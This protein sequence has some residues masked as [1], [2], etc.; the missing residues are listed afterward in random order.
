MERIERREPTAVVHL[1]VWAGLLALTVLTVSLAGVGLGRLG[2]VLV[3]G[4]A[5]TK[6]A[7]IAAYFMHLRY[8]KIRLYV[9]LILIAL[10]T[11]A[12]FAGLT[13]LEVATR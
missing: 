11:L 7:L 2:I 4:I 1:A 3:L 13:I 9:G 8:E 10:A 6:S 12:V 5:G